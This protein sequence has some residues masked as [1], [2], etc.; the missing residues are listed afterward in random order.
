MSMELRLPEVRAPAGP[1]HQ[2]E[3]EEE[4]SAEGTEVPGEALASCMQ[5]CSPREVFPKGFIV[6]AVT[7]PWETP[8]CAVK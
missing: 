7:N 1:H 4:L 2:L 3:R 5:S 8:L 6:P